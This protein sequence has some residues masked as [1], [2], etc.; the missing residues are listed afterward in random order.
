MARRRSHHKRS[1]AAQPRAGPEIAQ[2]DP[3]WVEVCGRRMFVAGYTP[4]GAPFGVFE[5]E[6]DGDWEDDLDIA[7]GDGF[8]GSSLRPR[9]PGADDELSCSD[10]DGVEQLEC[11]L[12]ED[13]F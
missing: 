4:G 12:A 9:P 3:E 13:P 7:A 6:M 11:P 8:C 10:G 1:R 2:A 5:D